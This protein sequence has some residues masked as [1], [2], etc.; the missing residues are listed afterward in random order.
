MTIAIAILIGY[1]GADRLS[2]AW[3]L[4]LACTWWRNLCRFDGCRNH[5]LEALL[6]ATALVGAYNSGLVVALAKGVSISGRDTKW[7][8]LALPDAGD[9]PT[10]SCTTESPEQCSLSDSVERHRQ[11]FL[12]S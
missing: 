11:S 1:L 3:L 7:C 2:G 4:G 8:G 10:T 9:P 6:S 12:R 5:I